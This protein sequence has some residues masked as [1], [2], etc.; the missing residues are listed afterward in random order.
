[1]LLTGTRSITPT[2][3][4]VVTVRRRDDLESV[5]TLHRN[6]SAVVIKDPIA[7]KYHRLRP[8]EFFVLQRLD[9]RVSLQQLRDEYQQEFAPKKVSNSDLNRLLF[10]LHKCGLTIS[11]AAMQG[12]RLQERS[13]EDRRQRWL[14]HLASLLF[15]RFPGVDPEPLLKRLYPFARPL[16]GSRGLM[17]AVAFCLMA[18]VTLVAKWHS[19]AAEFPAMSDW[20]QFDSILILAL[21]IGTTKVLHELG[22][23]LT[24]KHF[25]GECHEIGPMLLVFT[26]ALY[27]D[28]S[29]SW[30]LV[31]RWQRAAVGMAGI[32]TEMVVAA[33]AVF[34]WAA[35]AP[36]LTHYVAMNVRARLQRQHPH[37]QCQP[38]VAL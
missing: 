23:A 16:M 15:I 38:V 9:G 34:V 33:A 27:C 19:F 29:D 24:C 12:D 25:G 22:H 32:A 11:D 5:E 1:M 31:S 10:R 21:V 30:M 28:T 6:E 17:V 7:M 26:P 14:Q 3:S 2:A 37:F 18:A 36:G 4:Q 35:T 8:D 20:L 13:R